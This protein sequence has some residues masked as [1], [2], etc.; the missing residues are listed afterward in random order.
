[1]EKNSGEWNDVKDSLVKVNRD[2]HEERSNIEGALIEGID[3]CKL[4]RYLCQQAV[5]LYNKIKLD[6]QEKGKSNPNWN[7]PETTRK[8]LNKLQRKLDLACTTVGTIWDTLDGWK[9]ETMELT[10]N[11]KL[12]HKSENGKKERKGLKRI[13]GKLIRKYKDMKEQVRMRGE[14]YKMLWE[15]AIDLPNWIKDLKLI[16]HGLV[17]LPQETEGKVA[18]TDE[19]LKEQH[20]QYT[21]RRDQNERFKE[22]VRVSLDKI[23]M[24]LKFGIFESK[25]KQEIKTKELPG[26]SGVGGLQH[27]NLELKEGSSDIIMSKAN[28]IAEFKPQPG[29]STWYECIKC[30]ILFD[31]QSKL[32]SHERL[33]HGD[34]ESE[35]EKETIHEDKVI[36]NAKKSNEDPKG[37]RESMGKKG[38]LATLMMDH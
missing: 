4:L 31:R 2:L 24:R 17:E 9:E 12:L 3:T 32:L 34:S 11:K 29:P 21:E 5:N 8:D 18:A 36:K 20:W 22:E 30:N 27:V 7:L 26:P 38:G 6:C 13:L 33:M 28:A 19:S 25:N 23:K 15:L 1:M 35:S 10:D 16:G 37:K 14:T